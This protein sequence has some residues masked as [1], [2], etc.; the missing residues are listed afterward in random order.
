MRSFVV[1]DYGVAQHSMALPC[2]GCGGRTGLLR[3]VQ[4]VPGRVDLDGHPFAGHLC[5]RCDPM[6]SSYREPST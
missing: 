4:D 3:W 6:S 5:R 2:I 1:L